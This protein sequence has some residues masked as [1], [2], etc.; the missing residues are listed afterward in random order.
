MNT[1]EYTGEARGGPEPGEEK[2]EKRHD[3]ILQ[4]ILERRGGPG[5]ENMKRGTIGYEKR[6]DWILQSILERHG[7]PGEEKHE[8]RY[9]LITQSTLERLCA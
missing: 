5:E 2:R 4:S 9:D 7:G 1:T 8:K 3:W 6:Y